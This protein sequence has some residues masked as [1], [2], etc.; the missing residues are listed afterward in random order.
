MT[1]K[2]TR[3]KSKIKAKIRDTFIALFL[4]GVCALSLLYF[5]QDLNHSFTRSDKDAIATISFKY[6]VAQRKFSDRVVWERLQQNSPLYSEDTIRTSDMASATIT[7]KSGEVLEVHENSMIQIYKNADGSVLLS[8]TDGGID[9]D[10]S[11]GDSGVLA[12]LMENGSSIIVEKGSRLAANTNADGDASF[13]LRSGNGSIYSGS[14]SSEEGLLLS[15][16]EAV[17]VEN[18]GQVKK[19]PLSVTSIPGDLLI[20][21]FEEQPSPVHL[22]WNASEQLSGKKIIVQTSKNI[23]FSSIARSF[24]VVNANSVELPSEEGTVYWRVFEASEK[25]ESNAVKGRIRIENISCPVLNSPANNSSYKYRKVLPVIN[26]AW[27]GNDYAEY[28]RLEVA[29]TPDFFEPVKV[30][31]VPSA[32]YSLRDLQEGNYFWR[33]TP[34]YRINGT[35]F[36]GGSKTLQFAVKKS[37]TLDLPVA[38]SPAEGA[39]LFYVGD[40]L[41]T[42]FRWKSDETSCDYQI[43]VSDSKDFDNIIFTRNAAGKFLHSE[44]TPEVLPVGTYYWRVKRR[45]L[46]S[47]GIEEALSEPKQF[48]VS[49]YV[50]QKNRLIYPPEN[51]SIEKENLSSVSFTWKTGDELKQLSK[52]DG[53]EVESLIQFA[54]DSSFSEVVYENQTELSELSGV[55]LDGGIYF[56]R[57]GFALSG[58]SNYDFISPNRISVLNPLT[59]PVITAP[60]AGQ[61]VMVSQVR[62]VKVS[63]QSVEG[64]DYYIVK[65]I[66]KTKNFIIEESTAVKD[67]EASFRM[68]NIA[69]K[70]DLF[71][72]SVQPVTEAT[73]FSGIKRGTPSYADFRIRNAEPVKLISPV[74]NVKIDGLKAFREPVILSWQNGMDVP[75]KSQFILQKLQPAGNFKTLSV[76][77]NPSKLVSMADLGEGTYRW[78]VNASLA[79]G[80][81][82]NAANYQTFVVL[83]VPEL[84]KPVLAEPSMNFVMDAR[85]LRKNRTLRFRWNA[86]E[87]ATDYTFSL[88]KK[89]PGAAGGSGGGVK[90]QHIITE[91]TGKNTFVN[92]KDLKLLDAGEFEWQVTAFSYDKKGRQEQHSKVSVSNF[93]IKIDLPGTVNIKDPGEIFIE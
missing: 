75:E 74:A 55:N 24:S 70:S 88:Y 92:F 12:V 41:A 10:T 45:A 58:S 18:S 64:A 6:K 34:F 28:Y 7:F 56:W 29:K 81:P 4:L 68:E 49:F 33:V 11:S 17:K 50:P 79:D 89:I 35:G 47:E 39:N 46:A 53:K 69:E 86:V 72:C 30:V 67:L 91:K 36:A 76:V 83:P 44:F 93:S 1:K 5:W 32:N 27:D 61:T 52:K 59:P 82:V 65:L 60:F 66:N 85:F 31:N 23:D 38:V 21:N 84:N 15:A 3:S 26:F 51:F 16:G 90:M 25:D 78:T 20:L 2:K 9:V 73:D 13:L 62:P 87:G 37:D 71:E 57:V 63:W 8:V 42:T 19:E 48:N 77:E 22:E 80:T 14:D 54:K 43:L 40:S